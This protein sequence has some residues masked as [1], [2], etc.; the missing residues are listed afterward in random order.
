M[1]FSTFFKIISVPYDA[2]INAHENMFLVAVLGVL[3]AF[4]KLGIAVY[5]TY[6]EFD[7]LITYGILMALMASGFNG[8]SF[9][10]ET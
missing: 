1:V 7:G 6:A 4:L 3:E 9:S 10:F 5:I 8:Q 2:V